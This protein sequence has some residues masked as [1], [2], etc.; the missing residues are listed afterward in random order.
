MTITLNKE[1]ERVLN[2]LTIYELL[3]KASDRDVEAI[4]NVTVGVVLAQ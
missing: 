4:K 3:K 1:N 2:I